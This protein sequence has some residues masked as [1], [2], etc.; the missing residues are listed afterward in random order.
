[1]LSMPRIVRPDPFPELGSPLDRQPVNP[2]SETKNCRNVQL[3]NEFRQI[4]V[5]S[6][7]ALHGRNPG[8]QKPSAQQKQSESSATN[9][10][11]SKNSVSKL[12]RKGEV[13]QS[14]PT[15]LVDLP[16]NHNPA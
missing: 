16:H 3:A 6:G 13:Q 4:A 7:L 11:R 1:M 8:E 5:L 9:L 15:S 12:D 14:R 10:T 2:L